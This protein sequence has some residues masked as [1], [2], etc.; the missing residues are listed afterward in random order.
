MELQK[1]VVVK[2][3]DNT[4]HDKSFADV[5]T[6]SMNISAPKNM[7]HNVNVDI[8]P[9]VLKINDPHAIQGGTSSFAQAT[10]NC[11]SLL[12]GEIITFPLY[13]FACNT[14]LSTKLT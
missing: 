2:G 9:E 8:T 10:F 11:I 4:M 3:S 12:L 14:E 1:V 7:L 5:G 13:L 6:N